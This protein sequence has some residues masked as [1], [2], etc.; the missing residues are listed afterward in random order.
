MALANKVGINAA[1]TRVFDTLGLGD[2]YLFMLRKPVIQPQ[3]SFSIGEQ[4]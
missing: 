3:D 2:N 1:L 4:G